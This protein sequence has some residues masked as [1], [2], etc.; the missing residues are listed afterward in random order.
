MRAQTVAQV[1]EELNALKPEMT[2][3]ISEDDFRKVAKK[4]PRFLSVRVARQHP[5]LL[6]KILNIQDS[7]RH[8]RLA[9]EITARKYGRK[10]STVQTDSKKHKPDKYRQHV[11]K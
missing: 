5:D 10:L 9:Q 8:I 3:I 11:Q 1:I 7:R 6:E 2:G 4:H